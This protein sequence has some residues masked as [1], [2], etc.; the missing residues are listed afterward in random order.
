MTKKIISAVLALLIVAVVYISV[1]GKNSRNN[2]IIFEDTIGCESECFVIKDFVVKIDSNDIIQGHGE[3]I[4]TLLNDE[5]CGLTFFEIVIFAVDDD[6]E[7]R[8]FEQT[9]DSS[10]SMYYIDDN[11]PFDFKTKLEKKLNY[12]DLR[13]RVLIKYRKSREKE[14]I[15]L[16]STLQ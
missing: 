11:N 7:V 4:C 8:I 2:E 10:A 13:F 5:V 14:K 15:G 16:E 9:A 12:Q 6:E 1:Q 3:L